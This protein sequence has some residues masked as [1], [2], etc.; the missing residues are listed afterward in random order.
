[1]VYSRDLFWVP[2]Y[3]LMICQRTSIVI[4]TLYATVKDNN[5]IPYSG[6]VWRIWQKA[7]RSPNL[8][9]P[10][11]SLVRPFHNNNEPRNAAVAN[12]FRQPLLMK[13]F[14]KLY[15]RQT[16]PLYSITIPTRP[17]YNSWMIKCMATF[18]KC[19]HMGNTLAVD[20]NLMDY[21]RDYQKGER[22]TISYICIG[23][24]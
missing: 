7:R 8:N 22:K 14:A 1:M 10:N 4:L 11:F 19:K 13:R 16:F 9:H 20:Y 17:W 21:P 15:P 24:D 3:T 23:I 5:D 18:S 2:C 12:F 6:K